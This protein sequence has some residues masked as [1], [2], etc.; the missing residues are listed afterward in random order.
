MAEF[1]IN[2]GPSSTLR[3]SFPGGPYNASCNVYRLGDKNKFVQKINAINVTTIFNDV[4]SAIYALRSYPFNISF[5]LSS[6][7]GWGRSRFPINIL[8]TRL[9]EYGDDAYIAPRIFTF[10]SAL[11]D[12]REG[13]K[14]FNALSSARRFGDA[15]IY[16]P[17]IGY[18]PLDLSDLRGHVLRVWYTVDI[19]TG[20]TTATLDSDDVT[21]MVINGTLGEDH[22]YAN[23]NAAQLFKQNL[24]TGASLVAGAAVTAASGGSL[25]GVGGALIGGAIGIAANTTSR[26]SRGQIGGS[27]LGRS[28]PQIPFIMVRVWEEN[29]TRLQQ[30]AALHGRPLEQVRRLDRLTGYT[31][32]NEVHLDTLSDALEAEKDEIRSLLQEGV[33]L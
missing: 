18:T 20:N 28:G 11:F 22:F 31:E 7:G 5:L 16:L 13:S 4:G 23:T 29:Q 15:Q 21:I 2:K 19:A 8:N 33:I 27:G 32:F 26:V 10:Q 6:G 3:Y 14:I 25:V 30:F 12:G 1:E 17:Y 9:T 24:A